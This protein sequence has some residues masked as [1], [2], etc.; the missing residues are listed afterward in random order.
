MRLSSLLSSSFTA[1]GRVP[2]AGKAKTSTASLDAAESSHPGKADQY[3]RAARVV[4]GL[5]GQKVVPRTLPL[6]M[7]RVNQGTTQPGGPQP[8]TYVELATQVLERV[9]KL[10]HTMAKRAT[11]H[12]EGLLNEHDRCVKGRVSTGGRSWARDAKG[13]QPMAFRRQSA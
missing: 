3:D 11:D 5:M 12:I 9:R 4:L 1:S 13:R 2:S 8:L 10:P 6:F 7:T